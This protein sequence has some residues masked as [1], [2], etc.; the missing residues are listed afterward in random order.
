MNLIRSYPNSSKTTPSKSLQNYSL[1]GV[2]LVHENRVILTLVRE[3]KSLHN[4]SLRGVEL[5]PQ[6]DPEK[7]AILTLLA[8]L[9]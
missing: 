8:E 6:N 1:K 3:L 5:T 4:Y 7:G 9:N 2:K